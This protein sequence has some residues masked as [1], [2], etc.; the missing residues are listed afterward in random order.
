MNSRLFTVS[1]GI[2]SSGSSTTVN[3]CIVVTEVHGLDDVLVLEGQLFL[4]TECAPHLGGKSATP[5]F[6]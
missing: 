4:S 5:V 6:L 1:G 2:P 3:A